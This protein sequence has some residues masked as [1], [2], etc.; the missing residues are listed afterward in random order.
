[1]DTRGRR[2]DRASHHVATATREIPEALVSV[3]EQA[4]MPNNPKR[5]G[6]QT[7]SGKSDGRE[8]PVMPGNA[9]G[10]KAATPLE[11]SRRAPSVRRDGAAVRTRLDR[12]TRRAR[13]NPRATF[14]NLFSHLDRD[15]LTVC[16]GELG[17]DRAPGVDGVTRE[18]YEE[19]FYDL[20]YGFR[21]GRNQHDALKALSRII[22]TRRVNWIVEADIRGFYDNVDHGWL[23]RLVGHRVEDPR[24]LRLIHR[25]LTAGVMEEGKRLPTEKGTPQG[26]VI[27]ALLANVYLHYALD[28][29]FVKVVG[30]HM[31]G[32]AYLV[33]F[34]DDFIACFQ[35]E[36]DARRFDRALRR[37][38]RKFG[39]EVA[40]EKTRVFRFG[41]F[42]KRDAARRG[43][44]VEVF[45]FLGLTH[46]CG[47]SRR[48]GFKL[49]WRTAGSRFRSK[50]RGI[51][52]W[53]K[54]NLTQPL[55]ELWETVNRKLAG[56]Y[57]YYGV[58]DNWPRLMAF[59]KAVLI[60]LFKWLN[61]RSQRRSF[62]WPKF[63]AY[64]DRFGLASPKRL[65][66][67]N[68]AFV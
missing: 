18:D 66:N 46:Y 5:R 38:L 33:R 27:S 28:D 10:G 44:R 3:G 20:S 63:Y 19:D 49:K 22:G 67:L 24:I 7:A 1:M 59:R 60:L 54:G 43:E 65:V 53:L 56:H 21:P 42:A 26:G 29:W 39:L 62:T 12:I 23:M 37:R 9:G 61:R 6:G 32:E 30:K 57:Q 55:R 11:R 58:S 31:R 34:A 16:V 64:V 25:F 13:E 52:Q 15:L 40:E 41:R 45:D 50:L 47:K 48:G 4:S 2:P 14:T 35:Y 51:G 8:V 36:T 68:S 17:R